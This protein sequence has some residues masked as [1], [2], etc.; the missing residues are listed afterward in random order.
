MGAEAGNLV[1]HGIINTS[2]GAYAHR[3]V[4]LLSEQAGNQQHIIYKTS[5]IIIYSVN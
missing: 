5:A 1:F 2:V 3:L 4:I